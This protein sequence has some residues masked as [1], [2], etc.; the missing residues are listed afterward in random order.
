MFQSPEIGQ[1]VFYT[2]RTSEI[3]NKKVATVP[4]LLRLMHEAAMENVLRIKLSVW[5]LEPHGISW[6]LIRKTLKINRLP[7][8]RERVRIVTYPVSFEKFFTFRDYR[9]YDESGE[10]IASATS[11][12]LLMD[13]KTRR[14]TRIPVFIME[15]QE[16]MPAKETCLPMEKSKMP[17]FENADFSKTFNVGWHDLDFNNHLS[18]VIY[19]QWILEALEDDILKNKRPVEI[20]LLYKIEGVWKDE[21]SSEIQVLDDGSFLHRLVRVSDG[22]ELAFAQSK[23]S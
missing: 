1:E 17:K 6:V 2:I 13:T 22:K 11:H 23:W 14:M 15:Y 18:N 12:W 16:K 8:L 7:K 20:E 19:L 10:M 5:D 21:I 3:D 4:A 9:V